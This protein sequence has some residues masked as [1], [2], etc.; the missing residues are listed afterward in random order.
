[1][2]NFRAFATAFSK[3]FAT[4]FLGR[5]IDSSERASLSNGIGYSHLQQTSNDFPGVDVEMVRTWARTLETYVNDILH[6]LIRR[7]HLI[8]AA[9][10]L[11]DD[12]NVERINSLRTAIQG[13]E[14]VCI[15]LS[16]LP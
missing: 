6:R 2:T 4:S 9:K 3:A 8:S 14:Y 15:F 1:M 11:I 10:Q 13:M 16:D 12:K 5:K 7:E